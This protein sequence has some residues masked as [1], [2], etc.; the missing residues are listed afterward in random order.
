MKWIFARQK[1]KLRMRLFTLPLKFNTTSVQKGFPH[2]APYPEVQKQLLSPAPPN[3]F[4]N[5]EPQK[6]WKAPASEI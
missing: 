1:T 3:L 5:T 2:P 4:R 6:S